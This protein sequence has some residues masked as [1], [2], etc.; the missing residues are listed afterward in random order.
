MISPQTMTAAL[1][2]YNLTKLDLFTPNP[3]YPENPFPVLRFGVYNC[4]GVYTT[5]FMKDEVEERA[6]LIHGNNSAKDQKTR[7][8]H[9]TKIEN[10]MKMSVV[11]GRWVQLRLVDLRDVESASEFD[12][13]RSGPSN[14][15]LPSRHKEYVQFWRKTNELHTLIEH[16]RAGVTDV[17]A[18]NG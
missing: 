3:L 6:R 15:D 11:G 5:M 8:S 16:E 10:S 13:P 2:N 12:T 1:N 9:R 18:E 7:K 14:L 17:D 4:M